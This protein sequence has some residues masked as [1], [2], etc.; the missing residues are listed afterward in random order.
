MEEFKSANE[1]EVPQGQAGVTM[2]D[3]SFKWGFRV[4]LDQSKGSKTAGAS[5]AVDEIDEPTIYNLNF[6]MKSDSTLMIVG[7]IGCGKTTLLYSIMSETSH[8]NGKSDVRGKIAYVEQEPFIM[9][10]TIE[11]NVTFGLEFD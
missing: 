2:K 11:S 7:K 1:T 3:A 5:V 6:D 10:G 8:M 9:S 4:S